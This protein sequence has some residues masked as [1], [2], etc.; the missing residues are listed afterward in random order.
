LHTTDGRIDLIL[1]DTSPGFDI[2][3]SWNSLRE[4]PFKIL[5]DPRIDASKFWTQSRMAI[6]YAS[7]D[8]PDNCLKSMMAHLFQHHTVNSVFAPVAVPVKESHWNL[9]SQR[10]GVEPS[11][12]SRTVEADDCS[13]QL[14]SSWGNRQILVWLLTESAWQLAVATLESKWQRVRPRVTKLA[15]D[16]SFML[17]T[18]LRRQIADAQDLIAESRESCIQTIK[19]TRHWAVNGQSIDADVFWSGKSEAPAAAIYRHA[20][21]MDIRNLPNAFEK[22]EERVGS[23]T[24]AINQEIQVVIGSVQVEDAKTMKRQTEWMVAL[25]LL[26]AV[27]LPMT[28]V[29]GIFGMNISEINADKTLPSRWAAVKAWGIVFGATLGCILVYAMARRPMRWLLDRRELAKLQAMDIE[30]LKVD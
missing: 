28:L 6:Q 10:H 21:S 13:S 8:G 26:A 14:T 11:F 25:A 4:D 1:V 20:Q 17:L 24:R 27:Y 19:E 12:D 15:G 7:W 18:G 9:K 30:A 29:T 16:E 5:L 23:M 2:E 22:M 3:L